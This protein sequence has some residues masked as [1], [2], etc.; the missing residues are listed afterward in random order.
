MLKNFAANVDVSVWRFF[1]FRTH[2][3]SA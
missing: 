1:S 3:V 2:R